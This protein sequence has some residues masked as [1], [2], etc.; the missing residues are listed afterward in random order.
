MT[1][2]DVDN[3]DDAVIV[4]D[5]WVDDVIIDDIVT[6]GNDSLLIVDG[7]DNNVVVDVIINVDGDDTAGL[8]L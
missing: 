3:V 2:D 5:L 8:Q 7:S 1:I 4:V 6:D